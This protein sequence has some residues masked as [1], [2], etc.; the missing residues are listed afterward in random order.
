MKNRETFDLI[1]DTRLKN[2]SL[3]ENESSKICKVLKEKI[4]IKSAASVYQFVHLFN[5]SS[6]KI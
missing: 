5:L 4:Q 3:T 2:F 6:L 1:A